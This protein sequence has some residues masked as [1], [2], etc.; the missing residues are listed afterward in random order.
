MKITVKAALLFSA[1]FVVPSMAQTG[2]SPAPMPWANPPLFVC[3]IST[4]STTCPALDAQWIT[5]TGEVFAAQAGDCAAPIPFSHRTSL[6]VSAGITINTACS[7]LV[8]ILAY[9]QNDSYTET[10]TGEAEYTIDQTLFVY[11]YQSKGCN[12]TRSQEGDDEAC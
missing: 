2:N 3:S 10:A 1:I 11:G 5:I 4:G 12:G 8:D 7:E 6:L 9:T